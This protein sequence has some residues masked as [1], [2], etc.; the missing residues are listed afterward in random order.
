LGVEARA[1]KGALN[2]LVDSAME[3]SGNLAHFIGESDEFLG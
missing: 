1:G 3:D 2:R